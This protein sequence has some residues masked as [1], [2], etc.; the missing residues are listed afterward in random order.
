MKYSFKPNLGGS[1]TTLDVDGFNY[2]EAA[3]NWEDLEEVSPPFWKAGSTTEGSI[4]WFGEPLRYY[5]V[6]GVKPSMEVSKLQQELYTHLS[7]K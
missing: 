5:G 3:C 7:P 1:S 6:F 2:G 4:F